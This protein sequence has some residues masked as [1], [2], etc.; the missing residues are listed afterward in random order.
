MIRSI[1]LTRFSEERCL[2][3]VED[4]GSNYRSFLCITLVFA[5][6]EMTFKIII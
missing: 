1:I 6:N 2:K 5:K 3:I 4:F